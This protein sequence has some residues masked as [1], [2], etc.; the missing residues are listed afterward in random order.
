MKSYD[1]YWHN[2]FA[3]MRPVLHLIEGHRLN[4]WRGKAWMIS[5]HVGNAEYG[6]PEAIVTDS[7]KL[8]DRVLEKK[9]QLTELYEEFLKSGIEE[10]DKN[11]KVFYEMLLDYMRDV[12][13]KVRFEQ[14]PSCFQ[15]ALDYVIYKKDK[16]EEQ[17]ADELNMTIEE[18]ERKK[19]TDTFTRRELS[20]IKSYLKLSKE[21]SAYLLD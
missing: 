3:R 10:I 6:N 18:F 1:K 13:H 2:Y 16:C 14:K 12:E 21:D 5:I 9:R 19:E 11:K 15:Q 8:A 4:A 7:V 20:V 17:V